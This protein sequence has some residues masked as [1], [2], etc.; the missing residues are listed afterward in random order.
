MLAF[1]DF[2]PR[3]LKPPTWS[4]GLGEWESLP[5]AIAAANEWLRTEDIDLINIETVVMPFHG[6]ITELDLTK[7]P[8]SFINGQH[9][10]V[11]RQFIRVWYRAREGAPQ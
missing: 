7:S 2:S 6:G 11:F 10:Y 5:E 3:N 9:W 4:R 8:A 1:R